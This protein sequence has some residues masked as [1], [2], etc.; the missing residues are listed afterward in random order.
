MNSAVEPI[1]QKHV[2]GRSFGNVT[3]VRE[4][5]RGSMGAVFIGFQKSLKR[6]VAVKLLPKGPQTADWGARQFQDEAETV[7]VLAHPNIVPIFEMGEDDDY[8]FQVMQL[9]D[10]ADLGRMIRHRLKHPVPSKRRMAPQT[11]VGLVM[12]VLEG[13]GYAHKHGVVHQD[14]KPANIMVDRADLRPMIVDFGIARTARTEY[15]AE[16]MVVGSALYLS[17]EQAAG[18]ETD[19]RTD[20]YAMGVVLFEALAGQLPV[21]QEDDTDLL[22]RKMERPD[23]LF[24]TRPSETAPGIDSELERII[25]K[26]TA[27]LR[28]DRF[29]SAEAMRAA[30]RDWR[31]HQGIGA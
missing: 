4:L 6:Q 12:Q 10:G 19:A 31:V 3:I 29:S 9:V 27:A 11:A 23:T 5:G 2:I 18:R 16:G 28:E 13:L 17:P 20:L 25:V 1:D 15:W 30:L 22:M 21:R 14:M 26:S 8:Y 7:A 24:L